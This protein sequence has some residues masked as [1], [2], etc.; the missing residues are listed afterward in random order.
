[1]GYQ[2]IRKENGE[3]KS[4][5]SNNT[6]SATKNV[7]HSHGGPERTPFIKEKNYV[8]PIIENPSRTLGDQG[9]ALTRGG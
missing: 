5:K 6:I 8:G 2:Q 4:R 9:D 3:G 1:M 7:A